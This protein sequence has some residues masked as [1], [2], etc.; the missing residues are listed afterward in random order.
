MAETQMQFNTNSDYPPEGTE[1]R[2]KRDFGPPRIDRCDK[3]TTNVLRNGQ[4]EL[5]RQVIVPSPQPIRSANAQQQQQQ[6]QRTRTSRYESD[7]SS[8]DDDDTDMDDDLPLKEAD[9]AFWL[10]RTIRG[11][12]YGTVRAGIILRRLKPPMNTPNGE[13]IEWEVTDQFCAVKE[14][15]RAK[16]DENL[17]SAENPHNEIAAMQY[18]VNYQRHMMQREENRDIPDEEILRTT[19][20]NMFTTNVMMPLGVFW[21]HT[22]L[23]CVMPYVNGGELFDVLDQR[24]TFPEAEARYWMLQILNGIETLQK[25]GICHRDMS[26]ENLLTDKG[27]RALIIDMG[28]CIKIPYVDDDQRQRIPIFED[29]RQRQRCLVQRD[30]SCGKVRFVSFPNQLFIHGYPFTNIVS[31]FSICFH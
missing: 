4:V 29:H 11:A 30:R 23:Y 25:A 28:M 3:Y 16:I 14:Y 17:G 1:V 26:L 24:K 6:Q 20:E 5:A 9:H 7:D 2:T 10:Q 8:S 15:V 12:I 13:I 22:N 31:I 27:G 19:E 18:L 21:D